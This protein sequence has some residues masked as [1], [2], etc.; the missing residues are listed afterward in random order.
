MTCVVCVA[1][2][3]VRVLPSSPSGESG[4]LA[5]SDRSPM[6]STLEVGSLQ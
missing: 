1:L 6:G 2:S 3:S 4:V 5:G